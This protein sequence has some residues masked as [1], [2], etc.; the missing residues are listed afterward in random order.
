MP[1]NDPKRSMDLTRERDGH[2]YVLDWMIQV[3]GKEQNWEQVE[4]KR[5]FPP[6]IKTHGMI[7]RI[8]T[9]RGLHKER[10][11]KN[12]EDRGH[13]H[14]AASLYYEASEDYRLAQHT[15]FRD[16]DAENIFING[17][18]DAC[19]DKCIELTADRIERVDVDFKGG[20][21][22]GLLHLAPGNGPKPTILYCP[23]M[24]MTKEAFPAPGKNPYAKR[25]MNILSIDGPG[26]GVANLRKI[27]VTD[28]NYEQA[29]S[30]FIDYL[31]TR[32][33]V[34]AN[35]IGVSG[36]SNG[37]FWGMRIA[38]T[39][40]RVAAV[41][42]A[43]ANYGRRSVHLAVA[44]PR[45]K[46]IYMYMAGMDDEKAFDEMAGKMH[47]FDHADKIT[48]RTLMVTGEYDPLTP[49]EDAL[50]IFEMVK[51]PKELWVI[52]DAFH[53]M[54]DYDH[55]GQLD[56]EILLADWLG[57]ALAGNAPV[58]DGARVLVQKDKG[59]GVYG[60]AAK[61]FML[62]ERAEYM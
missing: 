52:E 1:G 59:N 9:K 4:A 31:V 34:D 38:A 61:G 3:T 53:G 2:Q 56:H 35:K 46:Q 45:F 30:V 22:S 40:K 26:Q 10:L 48:A 13:R 6:E 7:A 33:E 41:A 44:S 43:V 58:K 24:D 19:Y 17:K 12:A 55:F 20:R 25:G 14:T 37:S 60:E 21:L 28:D 54:N 32:P 16:D 23:G 39:D 50:E 47:L 27:R 36:R 5:R 11:A 51:G 62:P 42:T 15:I 29:A 49:L 57:D 8:L 18:M